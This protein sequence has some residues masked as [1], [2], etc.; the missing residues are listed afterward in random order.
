MT[1][2]VVEPD[3][4]ES[5]WGFTLE[6]FAVLLMSLTAI[7]T[8]WTGFQSSKW[9]GIMSIRFSEAAASRTESVRWSNTAA[10]EVNLDVSV[11]VAW[12]EA[13]A[14]GND[15]LAEFVRDRFPARLQVATDA[16]LDT[17]PLGDPSAP[18][19]PFVMDEYAHEAAEEAVR[20]ERL[21]ETKSTEAR[22]ANQR[23]DNY[24]LTTIVFASVIFFAALS[25]KLRDREARIAL[26]S[27]AGVAF[28]GAVAV[29][30]SFPIQW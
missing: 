27:V 15:D 19:S 24:I 20:L 21:A 28:V 14:V 5:R 8:A 11:F 17:D 12:V 23:S 13:T 29:V 25:S 10:Q 30:L 26:L 22:E 7:A 4:D 16:W 18:T 1:E 6:L 2:A 3:S 9:S